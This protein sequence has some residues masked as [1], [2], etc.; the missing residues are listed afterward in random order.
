[1]QIRW[2]DGY[3]IHVAITILIQG[4]KKWHMT[5]NSQDDMDKDPKH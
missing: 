3:M 1:M 5:K 2:G 4:P